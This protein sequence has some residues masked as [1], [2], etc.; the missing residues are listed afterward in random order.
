MIPDGD[1]STRGVRH[2][3]C[4]AELPNSDEPH[5]AMVGFRDKG[6]DCFLALDTTL[7]HRNNV[8]TY[9]SA[10]GVL[11]CPRAIAVE[12]VR[13]VKFLP[14]ELTIYRRVSHERTERAEHPYIGCIQCQARWRLG[15]WICLNCWEP[16][17][18]RAVQDTF[19]SLAS[20]EIPAEV[21]RRSGLNMH[22]FGRLMGLSDVSL[23]P[24]A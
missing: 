1:A 18:L 10:A 17:H 24:S 6:V 15:T 16:L 3:H 9:R 11:L 4:A 13:W 21:R 22:D 14:Q 5:H 19:P 7:M 12:Y 20:L 2:I 8:R 23:Q